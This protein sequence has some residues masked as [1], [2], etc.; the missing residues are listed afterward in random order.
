MPGV[1]GADVGRF[2]KSLREPRPRVIAMSASPLAKEELAI[3]DDFVPK[4]VDQDLLLARI[5]I[6]EKRLDD[7]RRVL[8][9]AITAGTDSDYAATLLAKL[10]AGAFGKP[11]PSPAPKKKP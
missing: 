8:K 3:F 7:A 9:A 2:V 6:E 5:Y 10:D 1:D 4:P 11:S